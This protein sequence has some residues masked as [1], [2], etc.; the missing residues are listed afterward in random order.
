MKIIHKYLVTSYLKLLIVVLI[1]SVSLFLSV[2]FFE[3][4]DDLI[5]VKASVSIAATYFALKLPFMI[6]QV[7]AVSVL[8]SWLFTYSLMHRHRE[9]IAMKA[10]GISPK[11]YILPAI[12]VTVCLSITFFLF[13]EYLERRF[14]AQSESLWWS[15]ISHSKKKTPKWRESGIWYATKK[16]IFHL[17]YYNPQN[18]T[19]YR[20]SLFLL[21][22]DFRLKKQIIAKSMK[23]TGNMWE[24][25]NAVILGFQNREVTFTRKGKMLI[26]IKEAPE[27]FMI[28]RSLPENLEISKIIKII[29]MMKKEGINPRPYILEV[30]IRLAEA[31]MVLLAGIIAA[32]SANHY[33]IGPGIIKITATGCLTYG[34]SFGLFQLGT[35]MASAGYV[36]PYVGVWLGPIIT[37]SIIVLQKGR[38]T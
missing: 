5:E 27:D 28:I 14:T 22:D 6:S 9:I 13:R 38:L 32:I 35:A 17:R 15:N 33:L 36:S 23:W 24:L 3:K 1:A 34:F 31:F 10:S 4:I 8:L 18:K 2:D 37:T 16:T 19:F 11:E 29:S 26:N 30:N 25:K 20:V 12:I 21:S 7:F